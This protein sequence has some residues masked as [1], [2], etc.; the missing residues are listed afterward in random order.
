M[1]EYLKNPVLFAWNEIKDLSVKKALPVIEQLIHAT[2]ENPHPKFKDFD[3][4]FYKCPCYLRRAAI[5]N[6]I[7]HIRSYHTH[8]EKWKNSNKSTKMPS[9]PTFRRE[10]PILYKDNMFIRTD[11]YTA[12]IK[13]FYK[14][15]WVWMPITFRKSD[16]DYILHHCTDKK[17]LSPKLR[18]SNKKWQLMFSFEEKRMKLNNT[19]L[20][21]RRIL[22]V[23][24]G[25]NNPA[26]CCVMNCDGTI[27]TR[28]FLHLNRD[29]DHLQ[30]VLNR[31]KR[32][33]KHGSKKMPA[34]WAK[35]KGINHAIAVKTAD[36]II[37][38]A[39]INDVHVIVFEHLNL[40]SKKKGSKKQKLHHWKAKCVQTLVTAKAHRLGIRISH[41][42]ARNTSRLAFDGSGKVTRGTYI[43][44]GKELYNYSICVFANNKI[45]NCDLNAS[46]NIGAR[47]FIR[48]LLKP[49]PETVKSDTL[50]KVPE[51]SARSTCTLSSLINL[52]AVL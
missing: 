42:N 52:N 43:Q 46:Y 48:E 16:V 7:G 33:Q 50:T 29:K 5:S 19:K 8:L 11:I 37:Q 6:V 36:Y 35:A 45:Y 40:Q 12:E 41:V 38:Q 20:K 26:T 9:I 28:S 15:D 17:E 4:K 2:K 21:D 25:I 44:N 23:D 49:L 39:I 13:V 32:A 3:K 51:C 27:Q 24:L 10:L 22:A 47:Y 1:C 31:I 34:L 30:F 14:N 18:Y